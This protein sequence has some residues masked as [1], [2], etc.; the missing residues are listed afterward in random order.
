MFKLEANHFFMHMQNIS[1]CFFFKNLHSSPKVGLKGKECHLLYTSFTEN[2]NAHSWSYYLNLVPDNLQKEV[3]KYR[4]PQDKFNSLF[5]K[6]L[7]Y[8]GYYLYFGKILNLSQL[9]RDKFGKP[10][11]YD[12]ELKFNISHSQDSVACLFGKGEVGLDMEAIR[13]IDI[14]DFQKM[15]TSDEIKTI[16][17]KGVLKFYEF[18]T[19]KEAVS[20]AIGKGFGANFL[21]IKINENYAEYENKVWYTNGFMLD[22]KY[23][24]LASEFQPSKLNVINV[25]F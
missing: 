21:D 18:W 20:K 23:Y 19:I 7:I 10:F 25:I 12:G 2:F 6:L 14:N 1:E 22:K 16:D 5:G 11:L 9:H 24:A 8:V 13:K 15:F 3:Q 17:K 4:R